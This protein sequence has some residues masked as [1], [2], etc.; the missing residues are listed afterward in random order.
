M[1]A[2]TATAQ[3]Q[4]GVVKT[5]G[6]LQEDGSVKPG[7]MVAEAV[8]TIKGGNNYVSD[9]EG[10]FKFAV[11]TSGRYRIASV[12]KSDYQL[13]D[14]DVL[15]R[16]Y[17]L[18]DKLYILLES[19]EELRYYRRTIERKV[20]AN[21]QNTINGMQ[22]ELDRLR[23][24]GKATEEELDRLYAEIDQAW[25]RSEQLVR[26]MSERYMLIDY[27]FEESFYRE[28]GYL[29][30]NGELERADSML[31]LKGNIPE[32]VVK[33]TAAREAVESYNEETAKLCDYKFDIFMQEHK[34]DSAA[35]YLELKASLDPKNIDWQIEAGGFLHN[36][37][38]RYDRALE[39][40]GDALDYSL[41]HYGDYHP[42]TAVLYN[43]IG[44][45]YSSQ[46]DYAEAL[47]YYEKALE[48]SQKVL[49]EYNSYIATSY[50]NIGLVYYYQGDYAEALNYHQKAL[51][52]YEK[53][54]VANHP[55]TAMSYNN[56]GLVF[57]SQGDY[58]EAL[59]Y[60]EKALAIYE[61]V[62]GE[63]HP[64]T[65]IVRGN[66]ETIRQRMQS[67]ASE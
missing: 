25:Q 39:I 17:E 14:P 50:N 6:R 67:Q 51:A 35:Y 24:E 20:R 47:K 1:F 13:T 63:G 4:H 58:A 12:T 54:L 42:Y 52:I 46:G 43:N 56:I 41:E 27:D 10:R 60:Y 65:Q 21:Y 3:L 55:D 18:T 66:I 22:D 37:L 38:A 34:L 16:E 7:S 33:G 48:I 30:L 8:V 2:L 59:K 44:G 36:Y 26:D 29:I 40:Y 53:V 28:V 61:S 64:Y 57:Y 45:A 62:L 5:R 23:A 31:A 15:T 32:R 9:T 11:P 49:G 19:N